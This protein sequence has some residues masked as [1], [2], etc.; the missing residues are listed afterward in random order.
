LTA[1]MDKWQYFVRHENGEAKA[2]PERK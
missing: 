1:S 2:K